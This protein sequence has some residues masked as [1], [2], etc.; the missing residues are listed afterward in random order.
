MIFRGLGKHNEYVTKQIGNQGYTNYSLIMNRNWA[1]FREC[2]SNFN[3]INR[4]VPQDNI[5][6][7]LLFLATLQIRLTK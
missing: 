5:F 2:Q 7:P 6:G 3:V 1:N 4:G